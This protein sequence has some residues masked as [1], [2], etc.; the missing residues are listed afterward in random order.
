MTKGFFGVLVEV[1]SVNERK[2]PFYFI[3]GSL[4]TVSALQNE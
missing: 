4:G 2:S 3:M 1:L